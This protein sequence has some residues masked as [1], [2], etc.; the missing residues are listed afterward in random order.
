MPRS[1]YTPQDL[2]NM[3]TISTNLR[4]LTSSKGTNQSQISSK[5]GIPASTLSG[6][7]N[8]TSLPNAGNLQKLAD[9]FNVQKSDI[10]PR[11]KTGFKSNDNEPNKT[12]TLLAAHIDDNVTDDEMNEILNFID[13]IKN[14]YKED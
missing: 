11:F 8:A 3:K 2:E 7:F 6:Y 13:Y 14:K 10:D 5:T 12:A 4:K 9:F 1:K